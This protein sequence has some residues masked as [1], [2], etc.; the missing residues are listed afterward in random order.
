MVKQQALIFVKPAA[1]TPKAVALAKKILAER[2]I[3]IT[4][5]K[6]VAAADIDKNRHIDAHY[7]AIASKAGY[8]APALVPSDLNVPPA[9]F[10]AEFGL[11]WKDALAQGMCYTAKQAEEC[12]GVDCDGLDGIQFKS[13]KKMKKGEKGWYIKF[14]GGF[15]CGLIEVE[16]KEPVYVFNGFF[17]QMRTEFTKPGLSITYFVVEWDSASPDDHLAS[18]TCACKIPRRNF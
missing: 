14:G 17:M 13:K 12:L 18:P 9:K 15:Y 1:L 5:E 4:G 6:A 7:Y 3:T 10:V 2:G 11:E 16:G 8:T